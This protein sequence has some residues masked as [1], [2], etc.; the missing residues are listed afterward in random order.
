MI[1]FNT[2][3]E[4]LTKPEKVA[5]AH[6]LTNERLLELFESYSTSYNP[7]DEN[8]CE[9]YEVLRAEM[10]NRMKGAEKREEDTVE[11]R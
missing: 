9:T 6:N 8:T 5:I 11:N 10:L 1:H 7:I 2:E 3:V 4:A